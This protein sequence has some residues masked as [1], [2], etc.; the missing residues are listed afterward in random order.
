VKTQD[1][2]IDQRKIDGRYTSDHF[3][4]TAELDLF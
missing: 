3:S 2:W 4:V 1:A